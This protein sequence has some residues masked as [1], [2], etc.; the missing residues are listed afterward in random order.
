MSKTID[1]WTHNLSDGQYFWYGMLF[2]FV[3][4]LTVQEV[5]VYVMKKIK[6]RNKPFDWQTV[7]ELKTK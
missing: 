2:M 3:L 7:D 4:W 1:Y 6:Q 5:T